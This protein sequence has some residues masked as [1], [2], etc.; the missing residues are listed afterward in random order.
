MR[1]ARSAVERAQ[2]WEENGG[3]LGV[4]FLASGSRG[5][6][7]GGGKGRGGRGCV[8]AQATVGRL[9][10][11]VL[12]LKYGRGWEGRRVTRVSV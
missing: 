2:A 8:G 6:R 11:L 4:R 5:L 12:C 3:R 7:R 9:Q 1:F 10:S